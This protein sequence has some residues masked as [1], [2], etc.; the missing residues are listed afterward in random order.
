MITDAPSRTSGPSRIDRPP[1]IKGNRQG[2]QW[3]TGLDTDALDHSATKVQT[4]INPI[5]QY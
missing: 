2:P 1:S 4:D 3:L 5:K